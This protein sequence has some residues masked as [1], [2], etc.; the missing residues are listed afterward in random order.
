[1]VT[2]VTHGGG[3][4]ELNTI[5]LNRWDWGLEDFLESSIKLDVSILVKGSQGWQVRLIS[6]MWSIN[7]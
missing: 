7:D 5:G 2:P 4:R 6:L 1:M 3:G